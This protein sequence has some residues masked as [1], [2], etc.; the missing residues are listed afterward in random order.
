MSAGQRRRL[1][2][3]ESEIQQ[4]YEARGE[5]RSALEAYKALKK[6]DDGSDYATTHNIA[7]LSYLADTSRKSNEQAY[8][9]ALK[10]LHSKYSR[11]E[12]STDMAKYELVLI[13]NLALASFSTRDFQGAEE[14]L[15]PLVEKLDKTQDSWK[16][17]VHG[18]ILCKIAF[19]CADCLMEMF[20]YEDV[21][22]ILNW[23][24]KY[25]KNL[26]ESDH[27]TEEKDMTGEESLLELKFRL[28]CY[29]A[30]Y[31]FICAERENDNFDLHTK[32]ARKELKNAN[33]IFNH[34][35][36]GKKHHSDSLG[37]GTGSIQD[38][39]AISVDSGL[40]NGTSNDHRHNNVDVIS[41]S[42]G[43]SNGHDASEDNRP[44]FDRRKSDHQY[45]HAL[46]LK[47]KL[48]L[49]KK[50]EKKSIK[51][52]HE[53][54]MTG[55]RN[56]G[57]DDDSIKNA[58]YSHNMATVHQASGE[59]YIALNHYANALSVL[60][61]SSTESTHY[62]GCQ[63]H[64]DGT[65]HQISVSQVLYN[66]AFCAQKC[67]N[68]LSSCECMLQYLEMTDCGDHHPFPWLHL[69]ESCIGKLILQSQN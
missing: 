9:C 66:A 26:V 39:V 16:N 22:N 31:H 33:E 35:L 28:H 60:E 63:L 59:Y 1:P 57:E 4:L 2:T 36:S 5:S 6:K 49:L 65:I 42:N 34:Q 56:S 29:R 7:L 24:E 17:T 37:D 20:D 44:L 19:L 51:L 41:N 58:I 61:Q 38:S 30:R 45:Q 55:E 14:I 40:V 10:D 62:K 68:Y 25:I 69:G 23:V 12:Y 21:V 64:E 8:L 47:A 46:Y 11:A 18:D 52:C 53:A 43:F 15:Y 48:E 27:H 50:N 32:K 54:K 13:Y 3:S 67:G